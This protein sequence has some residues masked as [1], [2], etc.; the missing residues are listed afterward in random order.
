MTIDLEVAIVEGYPI[1]GGFA[2]DFVY[3]Y[4]RNMNIYVDHC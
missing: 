2:I 1:E 3:F 4:I